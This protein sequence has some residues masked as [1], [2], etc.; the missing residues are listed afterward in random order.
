MPT[1]I[2]P[3]TSVA[4]VRPKDAKQSYVTADLGSGDQK[5]SFVETDTN[6]MTMGSDNSEINRSVTAINPDSARN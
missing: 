4:P 5:A 6:N 2:Q 3:S 1:K